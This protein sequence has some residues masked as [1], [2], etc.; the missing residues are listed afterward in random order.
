MV[1]VMRLGNQLVDVGHLFKLK[2]RANQLMAEPN[3]NI[4]KVSN[5]EG[6]TISL[7]SEIAGLDETNKE[8][9][10]AKY[11]ALE[12]IASFE[13]EQLKALRDIYE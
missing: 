13:T 3:K 11:E 9:Y 5:A 4:V 6:L 10:E 2:Q 7:A 12:K 8:Q 1:E